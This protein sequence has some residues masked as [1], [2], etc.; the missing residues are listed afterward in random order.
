MTSLQHSLRVIKKVKSSNH[1]PSIWDF[2][3]IIN[4]LIPQRFLAKPWRK[5][6]AERFPP[7]DDYIL[8]C[9]IRLYLWWK[10]SCS[11]P[12]Q[13]TKRC[14]LTISPW[15]STFKEIPAIQQDHRWSCP[16]SNIDWC[17]G[18]LKL[19]GSAS[20]PDDTVTLFHAVGEKWDQ[21]N[22]EAG[23]S[24]GSEERWSRDHIHI[25]WWLRSFDLWHSAKNWNRVTVQDGL[26]ATLTRVGRALWT[27]CLDRLRFWGR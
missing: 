27:D 24:F 21:R 8:R 17:R 10:S 14:F 23:P 1:A 11:M 3:G 22:F 20:F 15:A 9:Q 5:L 13:A 4:M 2:W 16:T 7:M 12:C 25:L 19:K 18:Y 26:P 6:K